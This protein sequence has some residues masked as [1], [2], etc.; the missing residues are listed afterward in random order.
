MFAAFWITLWIAPLLT[1]TPKLV[2]P[3][4]AT[5]ESVAFNAEGVMVI[6]VGP[7]FIVTL[8]VCVFVVTKLVLLTGGVKVGA[9]KCGVLLVFVIPPVPPEK[10]FGKLFGVEG[11]F[12]PEGGVNDPVIEPNLDGVKDMLLIPP[13]GV[14]NTDVVPLGP[15]CVSVKLLSTLSET[16]FAS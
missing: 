12:P 16:E 1:V 2:S 8:G 10:L 9:P 5:A 6:E 11:G 4:F 3:P 7:E 14:E 13:C 15:V